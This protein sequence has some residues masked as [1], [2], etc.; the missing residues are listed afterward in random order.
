MIEAMILD[1]EVIRPH[2]GLFTQSPVCPSSAC[3][4]YQFNSSA[5][6]APTTRRPAGL[7]LQ[8][9]V[10]LRVTAISRLRCEWQ[11]DLCNL[12]F[13][14]WQF[15]LNAAQKQLL[16]M[17]TLPFR[18]VYSVLQKPVQDHTEW[19]ESKSKKNIELNRSCA[20]TRRYWDCH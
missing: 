18:L 5:L 2:L 3:Q 1:G 14:A 15:Q 12:K 4:S 9:G 17:P 7:P 11:P 16:P 19:S 6:N 20:P 8:R 10:D 13:E